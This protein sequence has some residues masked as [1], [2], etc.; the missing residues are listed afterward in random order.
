[1]AYKQQKFISTI[2][3]AKNSKIKL[4]KGSVSGKGLLSS[5]QSTVFLVYP[6]MMEGAEKLSGVTFIKALTSFTSQRI[7][8]QIPLHWGLEFQHMNGRGTQI[9]KL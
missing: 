5:S 8:L 3:K 4:L 7:H 9:L 1:M 2:L 6:H